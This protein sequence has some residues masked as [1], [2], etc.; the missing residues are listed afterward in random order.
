MVGPS[1]VPGPRQ[2]YPSFCIWYGFHIGSRSQKTTPFPPVYGRIFIGSRSHIIATFLLYMVGPSDLP[3]VQVSVA[4]F[5]S[6]RTSTLPGSSS[7]PGN[8][9]QR[10][11]AVCPL[12]PSP[13]FPRFPVVGPSDLPAVVQVQ[14][15]AP[16]LLH[17]VGPSYLPVVQVSVQWHHLF[18]YV[19][20]PQLF[21]WV[22]Q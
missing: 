4:S 21:Y 22:I 12:E 5:P 3:V 14:T 19:V 18:V 8:L 9:E 16:F 10:P 11:F 7:S 15:I 17:M 13:L 1:W 6:R 2:L 20:E